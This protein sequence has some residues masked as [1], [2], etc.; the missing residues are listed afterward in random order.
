[1][2]GRVAC[3]ASSSRSW[4]ANHFAVFNSRFFGFSYFQCSDSLLPSLQT[5][6]PR[7]RGILSWTMIYRR[8]A[9]FYF[10]SYCFYSNRYKSPTAFTSPKPEILTFCHV[11]M[12]LSLHVPLPKSTKRENV[13]L[14][15]IRLRYLWII[16]HV[17]STFRNCSLCRCIAD[18]LCLTL[19][20][21]IIDLYQKRLANI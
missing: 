16:Y 14:P 7:R 2:N 12:F 8:L 6:T 5:P 3:A 1:M 19:E 21:L 13:V 10:S 17:R 11:P 4:P 18:E 9:I 20:N 15:K